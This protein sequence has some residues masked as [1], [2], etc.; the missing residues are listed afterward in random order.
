MAQNKQQPHEDED[1]WEE[2]E[3]EETEEIDEQAYNLRMFGIMPALPV[4]DGP[5]DWDAGL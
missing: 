1:G 5:P 2:D 3:E 4:P